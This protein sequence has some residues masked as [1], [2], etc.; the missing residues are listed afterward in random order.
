MRPLV[1]QPWITDLSRS[2]TTLVVPMPRT[3]SCCS[4]L[5]LSIGWGR[6]NCL[7]FSAF[8]RI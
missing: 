4:G 3:S 2:A 1:T 7:R 6:L 5:L 8:E